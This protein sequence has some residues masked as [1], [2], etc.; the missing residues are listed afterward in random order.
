M[1][2]IPIIFLGLG[3]VGSALL[4]Q[5]LATRDTLARRTNLR[6][7]LIALA[8]VSGLLFDPAG[9]PEETLHA[10]LQATADGRLLDALSGIRPLSEVGDALRAGAILADVTASPRTEPTLRAALDAGCGL[11]LANKIPLTG[12]WPRAKLF[13]K[14]PRLRYEVTVGAGLPVIATLRYLLDT[15][16]RVTA[17]AGCLSGTLGYLCAE[18]E[19]GV[20]YSAAVSQ[21]R[22]LGYT[23]PDPR[24]DLSGRDVARKALILART[25]GWPLEMA[26]LTVEPLY[27][28]RLTGV[29]TKE[30][31]AATPTLDEE[32]AARVAEAQAGGQVLRYV[33][34]VGPDGGKVGLVAVPHDNPLGALRGPANYIAFHTGRYAEIPLVISGPGAGPEVTAAGVLG[35]VINLAAAT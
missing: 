11:V 7:V 28:E 23:E 14:H 16:D 17:I 33:A 31:M 18:L 4:R 25:A 26:D 22:A 27:P 9:L 24:E 1:R 10:A 29:S 3:N 5:I 12:P 15:G 8:D 2:Q 20:P 21:A 35:D 30:F 19:R 32:Y 34:R 13:F 6:L